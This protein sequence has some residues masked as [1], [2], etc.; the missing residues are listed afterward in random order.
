MNLLEVDNLHT[1]FDTYEGVI[2]AVDGVS[3]TIKQGKTLGLM[4]ESGCGKSVTALSILKLIS[5]P[6]GKIIKGKAIFQHNDEYIDLVKLHPKSEKI[7]RIR[8]N[9]ISMI[10]Q[11]PMTS[12]NPVYTIGEQII[13]TIRYHKSLSKK[14]AKEQALENLLKVGFPNPILRINDYPH[15][16]SGGLR[17]RAMIAMALSCNPKVLIADEPTTALDVT[18]Q[19]QILELMG[20]L[21][22]EF[23][24]AIIFIS[25]DLGVINEMCDEVAVMYL[26][27]IIESGPV[28]DLFKNPSHPYTRSLLES[29]PILR[30]NNNK[31]LNPIM[32]SVPV[33]IDLKKGCRFLERCNEKQSFCYSESEIKLKN[34]KNKQFVRCW[35][36]E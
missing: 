15:H 6:P 33:P 32:G 13:E 2:Q 20:D 5:S 1:Y 36:Y 19:A 9:D 3:F 7:R 27:Q 31:K 35:L 11:D 29:M 22:S 16:L 8:G 25:H 4:G 18:V 30:S 34:I 14:E 28:N 23:N 24:M 12:L 17:Q 10:F 26:G 21:Q